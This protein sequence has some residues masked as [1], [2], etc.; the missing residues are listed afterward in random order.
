MQIELTLTADADAPYTADA[1]GFLLHKHPARVH[2]RRL[3]AG[4]ATVFFPEAEAGRCTAVL[5][6]DVDP[7]ALVRGK[8]DGDVG[9]IDRY[10]NDRPYVASSFLSVALKQSY[11]QSMAGTSRERQDLADVP[12]P[13][14]ARVTPVACRAGEPV[15]PPTR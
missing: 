12:L 13:F 1:L 9:L 14:E 11:A 3:S 2:Q 5:H 8:R 15:R 6:V 10:V 4:R 7:V